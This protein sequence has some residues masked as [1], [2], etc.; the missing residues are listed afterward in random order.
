MIN[1]NNYQIRSNNNNNINII[2]ESQEQ[3]QSKLN[4]LKKKDMFEFYH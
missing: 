2:D 1:D 4:V 3:Q